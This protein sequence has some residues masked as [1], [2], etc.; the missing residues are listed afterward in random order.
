M[1]LLRRI[2]N[3]ADLREIKDED[4]PAL[5]GEIRKF[6]IEKVSKTGG[7]LASNLGAVELT[8]ALHRVYDPMKDRILFDV[9]HQAYVHKMLTG[10]RLANPSASC[11]FYQLSLASTIPLLERI[12]YGSQCLVQVCYD[13]IDM[14]YSNGETDGGWSDVLISQLLR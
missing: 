7:H 3:N 1:D 13:I 10:R 5:C 2:N 4:L 8:V 6:L 14:L 9:G 12:L 11:C